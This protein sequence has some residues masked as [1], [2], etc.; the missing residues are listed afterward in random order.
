MDISIH[1]SKDHNTITVKHEGK[2][3]TQKFE[4]TSF[5]FGQVAGGSFKMLDIND[6]LYKALDHTYKLCAK[7][8]KHL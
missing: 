2:K 6:K 3:V 8:T 7:V 4:R 5:G 1:I